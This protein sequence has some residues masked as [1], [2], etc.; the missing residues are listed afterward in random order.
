M[1]SDAKMDEVFALM[2]V[3]C[4]LFSLL[5]FVLFLFRLFYFAA[6]LKISHIEGV[7]S[8]T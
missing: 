2:V 7:L 4:F 6:S 5:R 1:S 8:V 3:L